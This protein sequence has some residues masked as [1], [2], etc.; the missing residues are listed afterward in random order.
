MILTYKTCSVAKGTTDWKD[1]AGNV[2]RLDQYGSR[3]LRT[4]AR[5]DPLT[6]REQYGVPDN[7]YYVKAGKMT[8]VPEMLK[9]FRKLPAKKKPKKRTPRRKKN[10]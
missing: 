6:A 3:T 4:I 5:T 2:Y 7:T 1:A 9:Y 10:E 8:I